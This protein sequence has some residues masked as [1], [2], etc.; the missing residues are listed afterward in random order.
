MSQ[1]G[2]D[3][4]L[5]PKSIAVIGASEKP[6]RA[7]HVMMRN[8]LAS[9]FQ[10]PVLPVTPRYKAVRGVLAYKDIVSLPLVPDLAV[11]C[12]HSKRNPGLLEALGQHGCKT[13]IILSALPEQKEEIIACAQRYGIRL[14]G[15][16]SLGVLAPWQKLNAS[17][18]P[19]P[20]LPGRLGF[21]AHSSA[22]A[23]TVL[24]WAQQREI[25][26]SHFISLGESWDIDVDELLDFLARDSKTSA[27]LLHIE[28]LHH[29]RR[30][31]SASRSAARNKPILV[32]KSGRTL[33]SQALL[34]SQISFDAAFDAA[35]Q[36]A[37]ILRVQDTHELFS[38]VETLSHMP[39]LRGEKLMII[40][41][42]GAPAAMA[43]DTLLQ[44]NGRLFT[45]SDEQ[46]EALKAVL[47]AHIVINNPLNLGDDATAQHY[48]AVLSQLMDY[49]SCDAILLIHAPSTV[50]PPTETARM[51][52][53]TIKKH[54]R[55]KRIA[56]LTNWCGEHSSQ[57]ARLLFS[58]ASLPTYR[59][60]EGAIVA[61]MHMV[62]YRRNQQQLMETPALLSSNGS[63]ISAA[64]QL[65]QQALQEGITQLDTHQVQDIL[66]SFGLETLPTWSVSDSAEAILI[67]EQI[68]YP[69]AVKLRSGDIPYKSAVQ[70]VM[71]YL[72]TPTEV[73]QAADDIISRV[74][75]SYPQARIE[76]LLVQSMANRA[77]AQELRISVENDPLFGPVILFGEG[78]IDWNK[79]RDATVALP[80]LNMAL[81]RHMVLQALKSGKV[82]SSNAL[83]PMDINALCKLLVQVSN[84]IL[85]CPEIISLDFHPVLVTGSQ[86]TLLDV[87]MHIAPFEG[88]A[89]SRLAIRP[90]PQELEQQVQLKEGAECLFRPILPEDEPLLQ[91]F[92]AR[93]TKEDLYYRYFSEINEFTH[94][95]LAKMTQID[96]DREMAF[97]ALWQ[98]NG[99]S[100]IIGV[101]R[102]LIDPDNIDA[103]F[104]VLVRSDLKGLG[105]GRQ[106]MQKLIGYARERG[107]QRMTGIT[108][109]NNRR[110]ITLAKTLGFNVDI[111]LED[112]IVNLELAL[113]QE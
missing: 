37:G 97:V 105:L 64:R 12:T 88:D 47:P 94:E 60:P 66:H 57:E 50:S 110:M 18:S 22:V 93:V 4:L 92:I 53:E 62:E 13:A 15:P 40:S 41:N 70:G 113:Q 61:F 58:E 59:T 90:Y 84:L 65:I 100:E 42:G 38:A 81:A 52:I 29:A 51:A 35:V 49:Q 63:D 20:I 34:N 77:G 8:L 67:A 5:R 19:V 109:P 96:Y 108:M 39:P 85:H 89:Q 86:F 83:I 75:I 102:A 45:L 46:R 2:L 7:G 25:G 87:T 55:S 6:N 17:F 48:Q 9:G 76:G 99:E 104:S 71:L 112:S 1:R 11:L 79:E 30:F 111:Q 16:N 33:Q 44:R 26:F 36:R 101:T 82:R 28:H 74:G 98:Q 68:G 54:P 103:E 91:K 73:Q 3:A 106:L 107:L 14:L 24:D 78:G 72:R 95:D 10:G 23:N 31:L 80:P 32:I 69:V 21:I 56:I 43:M 27:I